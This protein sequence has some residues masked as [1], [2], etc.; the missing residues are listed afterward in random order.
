MENRKLINEITRIQQMMGVQV[1]TEGKMLSKLE[2][3]LL[4]SV[5]K[6]VKTGE[7]TTDREIVQS[8]VKSLDNTIEDAANPYSKKMEEK[9]IKTL[10][11]LANLASKGFT[12]REVDDITRIFLKNAAE[13]I[14]KDF[15]GLIEKRIDD[16]VV[17]SK[18][19]IT[20]LN[21]VKKVNSKWSDGVIPE[22]ERELAEKSLELL[23]KSKK[24]FSEMD[25]S[26]SLKTTTI[27]DIDDAISNLEKKLDGTFKKEVEGA[28]EDATVGE[29]SQEATEEVE[30]VLDEVGDVV[31]DE[32]KLGD[33]T[34]QPFTEEEV[35]KT[36]LPELEADMKLYQ[37]GIWDSASEEMRAKW[38]LDVTKK[39][40]QATKDAITLTDNVLKNS[41]KQLEAMEKIWANP[42]VDEAF[43]KK[44]IEESANSLG[45]KLSP[46]SWEWWKKGLLEGT[47]F[48]GTT[49]SVKAY[50]RKFLYVNIIFSVIEVSS[51]YVKAANAPGGSPNPLTDFDGFLAAYKP[52]EVLIKTFTPFFMGRI[53]IAGVNMGKKDY[54]I[55]SSK[56]VQEFLAGNGVS[57]PSQYEYKNNETAGTLD[58]Y[59]GTDIL[60]QYKFNTETNKVEQ[61][62]QVS[63]ELTPSGGSNNNNQ[64]QTQ[65]IEATSGDFKTW[66]DNSHP[67]QHPTAQEWND[68]TLT[69][70]SG[71]KSIINV[72]KGSAINFNYKKQQDGTYVKQ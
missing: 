47:G 53:I 12:K 15:P 17:N 25:I 27:K 2:K 1:I 49:P 21:R 33:I 60:G 57:T 38:K 30:N 54:R 66:Y 9:G 71:D 55:P 28:I 69:V 37:K 62:G 44:M 4:P 51:D 7:R 14:E 3:Y 65:T 10:E 52:G 61:F 56:E 50:M 8:F 46:K 64:T 32:S 70:N 24:A 42:N 31:I 36:V 35:V 22:T 18:S 11:D 67:T 48:G 68:Y 26:D 16:A 43:K 5:E 34:T 72:K 20:A 13:A 29:L 23:K 41:E 39:T 58:V 19:Y 59:K 45:L 63:A 40:M 6:L